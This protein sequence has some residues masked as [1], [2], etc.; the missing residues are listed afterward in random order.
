MYLIQILVD[1]DF[2]AQYKTQNKIEAEYFLDTYLQQVELDG[3]EVSWKTIWSGCGTLVTEEYFYASITDIND[4]LDTKDSR[5][6][7]EDF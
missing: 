5:L 3:G 6:M 2:A 1:N 7:M 4:V